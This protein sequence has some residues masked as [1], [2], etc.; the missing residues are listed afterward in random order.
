MSK[1]QLKAVP[2]LAGLFTGAFVGFLLT[3]L[4]LTLAFN[5]WS[6]NI[7]VIVSVINAVITFVSGC[8]GAYALYKGHSA[9]G[10]FAIAL[11]LVLLFWLLFFW[12]PFYA[13]GDWIAWQ[14]IFGW[15]I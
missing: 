12:V 10:G 6:A 4:E 11:C 14:Q 1:A 9:A 13:Y 7:I 15:E 2:L 8:L 3:Y 5:L